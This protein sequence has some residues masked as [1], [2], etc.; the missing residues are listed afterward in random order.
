MAITTAEVAQAITIAYLNHGALV[1]NIIP[2]GVR[3]G[4]TAT[5]GMKLG[6]LYVAIYEE[7]KDKVELADKKSS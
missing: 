6:E 3:K 5:I 2:P 4:D 7:I 1:G